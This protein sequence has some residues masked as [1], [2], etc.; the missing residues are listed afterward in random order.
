[1]SKTF[2]H[3]PV[4]KDQILEN[5]PEKT[6]KILDCTL[7]E[8]G[9]SL[10]LLEHCPQSYLVGIDRDPHA[11]EM[12]T[13]K[14]A[15][16]AERYELHHTKFSHLGAY[17]EIWEHRYD[18]IIADIGMSSAQLA[19]A[20]RGFSFLLDGPLDMRMDTTEH[21]TTAEQLINKSSEF[22]LKEIIHKYGEE[23][24]A[25]KIARAIVERRK[26][27]PLKTTTQLANLVASAIPQRFHKKGFHPATLTFQ[28]LRIVVNGELQELENLLRISVDYLN[29]GGRLAIISFHSLEDRMV[30]HQFRKWAN[31]CECPSDI[32]YCICGLKPVGK[33]IVKHPIRATE[34]EI[35]GNS[36]SRSARLRVFERL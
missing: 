9:H 35:Q 18:Y 27:S 5:I 31:P 2:H 25:A 4:L 34:E 6:E 8:G 21:H 33:V 29:P 7:G 22:E 14:L 23:R 10:A 3:I 32:P 12:T 16:F 20:E 24:F 36:R 28:A 19:Q 15:K 17:L 11:I 1:M 26:Q 13:I 30:K